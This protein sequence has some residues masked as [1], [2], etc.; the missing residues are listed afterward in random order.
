MKVVSNAGPLI[1]LGRL[2]QLGLLLRLYD[3]AIIP[4]QVYD[5]VVVAGLRIGAPDAADASFL[6]QQGHIQVVDITLPSSLPAWAGPIDRGEVATI[7]LAEREQADW[8]LID[9]A[10]ARAAGRQRGLHIKGTVGVLLQAHRCGM[11]SLRQLELVL[12]RAKM[13]PDLWISERL[14]DRAFAAARREA[15]GPV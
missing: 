6:I 8:V 15:R 13:Q 2:G 14:C 4:R 3:H 11:L 9:D 10:D 5:E 1:A 7:A 12:Q